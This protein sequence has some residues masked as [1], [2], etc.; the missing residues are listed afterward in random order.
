M[1]KNL[2]VIALVGIIG[3]TKAPPTAQEVVDHA[4]DFSGTEKLKNASVAFDFRNMSYEYWRENWKFSYTR[5][6]HDTA[7]NEIKDILSNDGLIRL[8]NG[9]EADI[10]DERRTAYSSSVNSVM[11][12]AFL[13]LWLNDAAVNKFYIGTIE[14]EGKKYY[15][16]KITFSEDGGGEDFEDIFYYWFDTEDYSMDYLAYSYVEKEGTGI[17]FRKAYNVRTINGVVIQ[18]Y[19]NMKPKTK[20]ILLE[21]IDKAYLNDALEQ[22]SVIELENVNIELNSE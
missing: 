2:F 5:I 4:I 1:I 7:N 8:I 17:R 3:C 12:F 15:K 10:T 9:E 13:P 19:V 18:D 22:L 16:I 14:M 11:Y 6:Q 21:E 20:D